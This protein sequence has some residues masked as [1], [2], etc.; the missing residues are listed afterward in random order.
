[1]PSSLTPLGHSSTDLTTGDVGRSV[2]VIYFGYLHRISYTNHRPHPVLFETRC[3]GV[4]K[5]KA[6]KKRQQGIAETMDH[7]EGEVGPVVVGMF[8]ILDGF[9]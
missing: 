1:M 2:I 6:G 5:T 8:T 7:G 9:A 4:V 3:C